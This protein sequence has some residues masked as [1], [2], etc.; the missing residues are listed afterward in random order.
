M[1]LKINSKGYKL[2]ICQD[3]IQYDLEQ[4]RNI[5][6]RSNKLDNNKEKIDIGKQ[7]I[8]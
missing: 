5:L 3:H 2:F 8:E 6:F 1:E 4:H 7:Q